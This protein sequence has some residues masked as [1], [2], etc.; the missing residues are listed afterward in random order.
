MQRVQQRSGDPRFCP[1]LTTS[2]MLPAEP[3][4]KL[5]RAVAKVTG[6]EAS[7]VSCHSLRIG[8]ATALLAPGV[9]STDVTTHGRW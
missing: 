7:R 4:V 8:G 1:V 3:V 9:D 5:S 2:K 6:N